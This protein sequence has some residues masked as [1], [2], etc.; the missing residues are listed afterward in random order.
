LLCLCTGKTQSARSIAF[1]SGGNTVS[2]QENASKRE[3]SAEIRAGNAFV[4]N[5]LA[6]N[7]A[8]E[9]PET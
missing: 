2:R 8:L 9:D 7:A 6:R 1:S 4:M 5:E 3:S